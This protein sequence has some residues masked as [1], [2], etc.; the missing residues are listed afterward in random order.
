MKSSN[1]KLTFS[2]CYAWVMVILALISICLIILDYAKMISLTDQPY[3][4]ID[5]GIWVIFVGD[6]CIRLPNKPNYTFS[7][8]VE[9]HSVSGN[10]GATKAFSQSKWADLLFV[11]QL[12]PINH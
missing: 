10:D 8:L 5:N 12:C 4:L 11:R 3:S 2:L 6:Y 9:N 7:S 1:K